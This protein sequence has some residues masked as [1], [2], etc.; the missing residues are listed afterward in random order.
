MS[1]FAAC[2]ADLSDDS[3]ANRFYKFIQDK[4]ELPDDLS[5]Y[6]AFKRSE[7]LNDAYHRINSLFVDYLGDA[8]LMAVSALHRKQ[9]ASQ[10]FIEE[11]FVDETPEL[12]EIS[13][14]FQD[15]ALHNPS[16]EDVEE[17]YSYLAQLDKNLHTSGAKFISTYSVEV[18]GE[19]FIQ[20]E[21]V[22]EEGV[23][24]PTV[25]SSCGLTKSMIIELAFIQDLALTNPNQK[26]D[27]TTIWQI[28][29]DYKPELAKLRAIN[30]ALLE[31]TANFEE[32]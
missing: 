7:S 1:R 26:R 11:H 4:S 27:F 31:V 10:L 8:L 13:I 5:I 21:E 23:L 25:D 30:P 12:D 15:R 24:K 19:V 18:S 32:A 14:K 2:I 16:V 20:L 9:F 28:L 6:Y 17:L 3:L 29:C 22:L